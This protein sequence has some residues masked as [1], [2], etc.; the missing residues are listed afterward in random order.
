[1]QSILP[2]RPERGL[3]WGCG[4]VLELGKAILSIRGK[5]DGFSIWPFHW[6]RVPIQS[7]VQ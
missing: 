7:D 5:L 4:S 1:M 3:R 2:P 6:L